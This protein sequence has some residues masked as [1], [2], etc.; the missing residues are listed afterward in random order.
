MQ[1]KYLQDDEWR[2]KRV[3]TKL[4][5]IQKTNPIKYTPKKAQSCVAMQARK[6]HN[7]WHDTRE[8]DKKL[9]AKY[10][11]DEYSPL[12]EYSCSA[13][14][15]QRREDEII[16]QTTQNYYERTKQRIQADPN[17]YKQ[18]MV[19]LLNAEHTL[20][21]VER[22][23]DKICKEFGWQYVGSAVH[24]DEGHHKKD[25]NGK[26]YFD[27]NLHA[28]IE[29]ITL[30]ENGIN[31]FRAREKR[32]IGKRLQTLVADEL[33]MERGYD[34]S[35]NGKKAPKGLTSK[36]YAMKM[37][38][39]ENAMENDKLTIKELNETIK[40]LR[41]QLKENHA[42]RADYAKLEQESKNLKEQLKAKELNRAE[43]ERQIALM[44]E[45]I[46]AKFRVEKEK[47]DK[48]KNEQIQNLQTQNENIKTENEKLNTQ[49][50]TLR[51]EEQFLK[52]I[53][54]KGLKRPEYLQ[55][56]QYSYFDENKG[57]SC[58][59][60]EKAELEKL[61]SKY[62]DDEKMQNYLKSFKPIQSTEKL[63]ID[64]YNKKG[65]KTSNIPL[66]PLQRALNQANEI[67]KTKGL[68][69]DG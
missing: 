52:Q 57:I 37:R 3:W 45:Q 12:N 66:Y 28:H 65:I 62:D 18:S 35:A 67:N 69:Y 39:L 26:E 51:L 8:E 13:Q 22:V 33:G 44:R 68:D 63:V 15:M 20:E 58:K 32:K 1:K 36:Q 7:F 38:D 61:K 29:F 24:R 31:C 10:I 59:L 17:N 21:D 50:S 23:A 27:P 54:E 9:K 40:D 41:E 2:A 48:E 4:D 42:T 11:V 5:K 25:E 47:S 34:Y 64:Y 14:E 55:F 49:I 60:L 19:I 56:Y 53:D 30:N 43:F 16:A 6:S 46:E